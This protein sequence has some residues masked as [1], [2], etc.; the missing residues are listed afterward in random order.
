MKYDFFSVSSV[1]CFNSAAF[2]AIPGARVAL[3]KLSMFEVRGLVV[4]S[5]AFWLPIGSA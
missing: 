3:N 4:H 1:E 5:I 2:Y